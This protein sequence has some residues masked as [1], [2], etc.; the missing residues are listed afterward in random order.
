MQ[1]YVLSVRDVKADAFG[2]PFFTTSIGEAV[3]NFG[4]EVNRSAQ[5]NLLYMHPDDFELFVLGVFDTDNGSFSLL[6]KPRQ[7][8]VGSSMKILKPQ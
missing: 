5:D 6:P 3:R 1:L 7:E 2:R 4:D 8:A